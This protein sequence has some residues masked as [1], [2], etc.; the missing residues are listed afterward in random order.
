MAHRDIKPMNLMRVN[1]G[2]WRL[3]DYGIGE[4]L[5]VL[6]ENSDY[7]DIQ[8][9][10]GKFSLSGTP[11]YMSPILKERFLHAR[12]NNM[13]DVK[14]INVDLSSTDQAG[15][16]GT[17]KRG[18]PATKAATK[19]GRGGLMEGE[20]RIHAH[21]PALFEGS[22]QSLRSRRRT[23]R[24]QTLGSSAHVRAYARG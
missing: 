1:K 17:N 7:S 11:N 5:K 10:K 13:Q 19:V 2:E 4:N 20:V 9:Q 21:H 23:I 14:L 12:Q 24:P 18:K 22:T 15:E 16:E 3:I 6:L 8:I